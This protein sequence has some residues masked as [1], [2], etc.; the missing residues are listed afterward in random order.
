MWEV[1]VGQADLDWHMGA[2]DAALSSPCAL[3][4]AAVGVGGTEVQKQ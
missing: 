4:G 3:E 2:S 1:F